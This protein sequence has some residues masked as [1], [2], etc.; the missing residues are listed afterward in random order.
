MVYFGVYG[1]FNGMPQPGLVIAC[2]EAFV[3]VLGVG[4]GVFMILT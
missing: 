3:G 2:M 4:I 1:I